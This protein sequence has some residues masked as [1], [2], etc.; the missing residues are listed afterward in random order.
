[1]VAAATAATAMMPF[2]GLAQQPRREAPVLP[3]PAVRS[4]PSS[5]T[6][7]SSPKP[8]PQQVP[9]L[10]YVC[11][12]PADAAVVEDKPG[13]CPKCGMTLQPIRLDLRYA[14]PVHQT[15]IQ[16]KPGTHP[17]DGRELVP[18]TVAVSWACGDQAFLEP[19]RCAD[20]SPRHQ[21]YAQRA[22]GDHNPKHG[23]QF[24][25]ASDAWHHLEGTY[26]S[27]GLF[28]LYFYNDFSKPLTPTG[29]S[30]T[31]SVLDANDRT[32]VGDLPLRRGH[33]SNTMEAAIPAS[34]TSLPLRL[35]VRVKFSATGKPNTFDFTFPALTKEPAAPVATTTRHTASP[36]A[37]SATAVAGSVPKVADTA[38][39]A[40]ARA[41]TA[42]PSTP[43]AASGGPATAPANPLSSDTQPWRSPDLATLADAVD[44][45]T[46][47]KALPALLDELTKRGAAVEQLVQ[48]G[49]L[50]QVWLPAMGTKTVALALASQAE[51]LTPAKRTIAANAAKQIVVS[52][53]ELD[54]YGD[55]GDKTK[56]SD[57]YQ[58]LAAAIT[59]LRSAYGSQ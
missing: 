37:T 57:A 56:M 23:G 16:E 18:V 39:V 31:L 10:S 45:T 7:P 27:A 47:P 4:S 19:G 2:P 9:P 44:E 12:M 22:H 28:R 36:A 11:P 40:P 59:D 14:C 50:G 8:V 53:W 6:G 17:Y 21:Q 32:I 34:H 43:P 54:K 52:A 3:T 1:M 5:E 13:Q 38:S 58:Q 48:A 25:M 24:F 55:L 42:S 20:G 26:A 51:S 49:D 30:A 46:L 15:Y 33:V 35:E 29:F 41:A